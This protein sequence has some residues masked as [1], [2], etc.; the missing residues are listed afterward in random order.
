MLVES[1]PETFTTDLT[2]VRAI[3]PV[4]KDCGPSK[5]LAVLEQHQPD[6]VLCFGLALGR[7]RIS[8]ERIAINL[9]G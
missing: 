1:I 4:D 2:L 7:A 5:L 6:T 3:L 8:L 9:M